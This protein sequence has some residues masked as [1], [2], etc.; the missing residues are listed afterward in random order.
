L[1]VAFAGSPR[2]ALPALEALCAAHEVAGV[3]TQP[4]RPQGR[5]RKLVPGPVKSAALARGIPCAQPATLREESAQAVLAAWKPEALIV[6]AYGLLLP[7][8][9]LGLPR[10]GCINLHASLLPRWRG[11]APVARAI[12]AGD[13]QTG[14]SI[15]QMEAGLDTGGVLITRRTVISSAHTAGSLA[16][17]LSVLGAGA[18][19][20]SLEGLERGTLAAVPQALE[21]V[22]YAR[23]LDKSEA[24]VDWNRDAREIDRQVRAFDP[25]PVAETTLDGQPLK[26]LAGH[27]LEEPVEERMLVG[28]DANVAPSGS[29]VAVREDFIAIQCGRGQLAVTRVQRPGRRPVGARDFSHGTRL[30]GRRLG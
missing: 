20:E 16:D 2:F 12:L 13:T 4:D 29:I 10:Y 23:K 17:E 7:Q 22:T 14:V 15:M 1:R 19:L 28:T 8:A 21:G 27:V 3:L 5:G 11:A 30:A 18:L 24:P 26:I 9:V 6:V 25:W